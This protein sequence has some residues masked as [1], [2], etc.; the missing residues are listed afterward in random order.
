M[1][2]KLIY[3][4]I[5]LSCVTIFYLYNRSYN[6]ALNSKEIYETEQSVSDDDI[7]VSSNDIDIVSENE[8]SNNI[9]SDN[10]ISENRIDDD[11]T[12]WENDVRIKVPLLI[13]E[14]KPYVLDEKLADEDYGQVI[15]I[16]KSSD[17]LTE[18]EWKDGRFYIISEKQGENKRMYASFHRDNKNFFVADI[19]TDIKEEDIYFNVIDIE[20]FENVFGDDGY[21]VVIETGKYDVLCFYFV[22]NEE[23]DLPALIYMI[24]FYPEAEYDLDNDGEKEIT[25]MNMWKQ[26]VCDRIDDEVMI[27]YADNSYDL[28]SAPF[29]YILY[30]GA[31][32]TFSGFDESNGYSGQ[33]RYDNGWMIRIGDIN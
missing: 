28:G 22:W 20:I 13:K 18:S 31:E 19:I 16:S 21:K 29:S 15:K 32:G 10:S 25:G 9:I 6:D 23:Y 1:L 5:V 3:V 2:E 30:E 17:W 33:Y 11:G 7:L 12:V 26:H 8:L 24:P 27:F 14:Y 4:V